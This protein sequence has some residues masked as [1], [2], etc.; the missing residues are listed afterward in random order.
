MKTRVVPALTLAAGLAA[1]Y[2]LVVVAAAAVGSFAVKAEPLLLTSSQMEAVTAGLTIN[3]SPQTNVNAG[4]V[5]FQQQ[6]NV[7]SQVAAAVAV[8]VVACGVCSGK[9]PAANA[10]AAAANANLTGQIQ[11]SRNAAF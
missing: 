3:V 8:P 1:V 7:T 9:I 2:V 10:A 4:D 5:A 11:G 6:L